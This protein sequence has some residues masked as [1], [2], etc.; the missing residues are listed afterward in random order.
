MVRTIAG[1]VWPEGVT[2]MPEGTIGQLEGPDEYVFGEIVALTVGPD[3]SI[4][5]F[6]SQAKALRQDGP[7][8]TSLARRVRRPVRDAL[9]HPDGPAGCGTVKA[10]CQ[11]AL[12]TSRLT[13]ACS[14]TS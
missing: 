10:P 1:S 6:D 4:Y 14:S 9:P 12:P 2:V 13:G 5:L 3:G 8:G 11:R 7:D